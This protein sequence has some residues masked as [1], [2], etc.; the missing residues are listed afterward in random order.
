MACTRITWVAALLLVTLWSPVAWPQTGNKPVPLPSDPTDDPVVMAA[1][2]LGS[3]P[4][5]RYRILGMD[6]YKEDKYEEALHYFRRASYYADKPS[7][8]MVGEMLWSGKGAAQDRAQA[9]AWMDLAAER[10]YIGFLGLR[11]R[12]WDQLSETERARALEE[13]QAIYAKYGD[14]A[15]KPRMAATLRR[16][17][18]KMTGSRTGFTGSL[19]ILVPGPGG[20][21]QSI[22]GSKYYDERYWDPEQYQA[23]HDAIWMRP[24]IGLVRVG[25]VE[26]AT[27]IDSRVPPVPPQVDADEP[28]TP[29]PDG[30]SDG[31]APPH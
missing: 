15:A 1:G 12:Y 4:D 22:D 2:F 28:P 27:T 3:H 18:R 31:P 29:E 13:G 14:D 17:R 20:D 25:E 9:Y 16:E 6:K 30:D 7:Q 24:R 11:E 10:G 23:W 8:G 5:M 19:Q 26:Q 21:Y